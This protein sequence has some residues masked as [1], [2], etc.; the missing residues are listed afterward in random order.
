[1]RTVLLR[2]GSS[3][4]LSFDRR[5][6]PLA[7]RTL[8]TSWTVGRRMNTVVMTDSASDGSRGRTQLERTRGTYGDATEG[9]DDVSRQVGLPVCGFGA[10]DDLVA[11]S[12]VTAGIVDHADQAV[13]VDVL[14]VRWE[15]VDEYERMMK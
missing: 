3:R 5:V 7:E 2:E 11:M 12:R 14:A 1:M 4:E 10:T 15:D 6:A 9:F 8:W 13:E